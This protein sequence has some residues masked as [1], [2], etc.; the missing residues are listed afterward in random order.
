MSVLVALT[1]YF[2]FELYQRERIKIF[3]KLATPIILL[4]D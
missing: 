2:I 3:I 1:F 4:V